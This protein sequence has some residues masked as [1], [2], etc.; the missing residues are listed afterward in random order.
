MSSL[1]KNKEHDANVIMITSMK[2][3]AIVSWF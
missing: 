2:N 3:K 1:G